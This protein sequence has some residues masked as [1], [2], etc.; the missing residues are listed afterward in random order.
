MQSSGKN[1][2]EDFPVPRSIPTYSTPYSNKD[3]TRT[4]ENRRKFPLCMCLNTH[5]LYRYLLLH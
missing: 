5:I 4:Q 2:H 1:E 3:K